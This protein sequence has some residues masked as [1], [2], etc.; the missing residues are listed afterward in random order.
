[1]KFENQYII[2][3]KGLKEGVHDFEFILGKP[4]FTECE[5]LEV[6]DGMVAAHVVLTRKPTFLDLDINLS[7]SL[8]VLCDRCLDY[9]E[10][11]VDFAGHLVVR[12][13]EQVEEGDDEIIFLNPEDNQLDMKHYFYE[14]ISVSLPYR[15]VHPDLPDGKSGCDPE[16]LKKLKDHLI[17]D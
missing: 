4:F 7:G 10:M 13:S 1:L 12:F 17:E 6:P 8:Q 9:F 15:K 3:F 11:D 2:Q 5:Y 16:M 14:C